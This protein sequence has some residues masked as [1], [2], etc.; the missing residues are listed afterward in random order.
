MV[1]MQKFYTHVK[2]LYMA[3]QQL[4]GVSNLQAGGDNPGP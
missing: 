3:M 1:Q 2:K 4:P